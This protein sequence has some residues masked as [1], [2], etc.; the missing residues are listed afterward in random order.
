MTGG[1]ARSTTQRDKDRTTI[2]RGRPACALCGEP[3]DYTLPHFDPGEFVVD[4]IV[5][6]HRGGA[7][8]LSNKQPSHRKCNSAKAARLVAPVVRRSGTLVG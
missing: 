8:R 4:H 2:S 3:I 6:L 1:A 5:P 7:D